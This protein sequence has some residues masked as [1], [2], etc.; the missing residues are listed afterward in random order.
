VDI[1]AHIRLGIGVL[2]GI[3]IPA[4]DDRALPALR[5]TQ[6]ELRGSRAAGNRIVERIVRMKVTANT[7]HAP[8]LAA[9]A[10]VNADRRSRRVVRVKRVVLAA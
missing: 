2:E 5:V 9:R 8:S 1:E 3:R 4:G 6:E 7:H 10:G